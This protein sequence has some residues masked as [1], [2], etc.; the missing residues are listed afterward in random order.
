MAMSFTN[1][2]TYSIPWFNARDD[3]ITAI[4]E[5]NKILAETKAQK[6][7]PRYNGIWTWY[8]TDLTADNAVNNRKC[9]VN[10]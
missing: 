7:S 10:V 4:C 1:I 9:A 3:H 6:A 8:Q 2:I 5:R